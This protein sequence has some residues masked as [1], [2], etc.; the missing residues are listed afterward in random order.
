MGH[1]ERDDARL[2]QERE[3]DRDDRRSESGEPGLG[4]GLRQEQGPR[5]LEGK[6]ETGGE[7]EA[8]D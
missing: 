8:R 6:D 1:G 3:Q 7:P 4:A 5:A 2:E